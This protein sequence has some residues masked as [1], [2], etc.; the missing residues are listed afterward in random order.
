MEKSAA[1]SFVESQIEDLRVLIRLTLEF[2]DYLHGFGSRPDLEPRH[3]C[4]AIF[5]GDESFMSVM[6][7][8]KGSLGSRSGN[9][10]DTVSLSTL[11]A[12]FLPM[13]DDFI[14]EQTFERKCSLLLDLFK[15]QIVFAGLSYE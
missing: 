12:Q 9:L 2:H 10:G 5:G 11:K 8:Y 7:A 13:F 15:L 1:A 3:M 4:E 6:C 14:A